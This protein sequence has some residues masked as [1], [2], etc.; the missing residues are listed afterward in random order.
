MDPFLWHSFCEPTLTGRRINLQH[1]PWRNLRAA[2]NGYIQFVFRNRKPLRG[3][4]QLPGVGDGVF[5]EIIAKGKIPQ[6]LEKRVVALGEA[7]IFQVVVLAAC[8]HAFLA[9]C[10]PRVIAPFKAEEHIL[11]LVHS[12]VGE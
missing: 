9:A 2:K 3:C 10:R 4:D 7:D 5:L 11:K 1:V 6:H 8:A 12:R